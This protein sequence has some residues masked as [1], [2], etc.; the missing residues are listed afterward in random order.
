MARVTAA[1]LWSYVSVMGLAVVL[2]ERVSPS[3]L[4]DAD[5]LATV[6]PVVVAPPLLHVLAMRWATTPNRFLGITFAVL[7]VS[8]TAVPIL[9]QKVTWRIVIYSALTLSMSFAAV[10]GAG[11][12]LYQGARRRFDV[13]PLIV[14]LAGVV[15]IGA[16]DF[17]LIGA[18]SASC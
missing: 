15:A 4:H 3:F 13:L 11:I 7:A 8:L 17:W 2:C 18:I 9:V 12:V 5:E 10:A 6:F 14:F 1:H 16:F